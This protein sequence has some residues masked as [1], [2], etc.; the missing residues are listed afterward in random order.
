M[1][2]IEELKKRNT[3]IISNVNSAKRSAGR[4]N[5][6]V[7]IIAVSKTHPTDYVIK[8]IDA[9]I[10]V[11]GENYAQEMRDKHQDLEN[12]R[13]AQPE[14]HFIGHLQNNKVKYI[15]PFVDYI[16]SVD[17]LKLAE[18]INKQAIK[19]NRKIK[20]M[21]QLN[22]SGELSKSGCEPDEALE[23]AE[24][25]IKLEN[26]ELQGLMTI[27]SFTDDENQQRKE[28]SILRNSLKEINDK[29][30]LNLK[31]LSMGMSHDYMNAINEGATMVRIGTAFFG[32]RVYNV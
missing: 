22:T 28:F 12:L 3:E 21:L 27:G 10:T 31:E 17:S 5:E 16:H 14:W 13:I 24:N 20:I 29:L 9:G 30:G 26:L 23:I 11:F 32:S 7:K 1:I 8:A 25:I 15:A 4:E 2:D 6:S 18:E 19:N